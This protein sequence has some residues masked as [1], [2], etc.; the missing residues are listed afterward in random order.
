MSIESKTPKPC[1]FCR[2]SPYWTATALSV[3]N[4]PRA[5]GAKFL[6]CPRFFCIASLVEAASVE[7]WNSL[8]TQGPELDRLRE[9]LLRTKGENPWQA[10]RKAR[11]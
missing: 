6:S 8:P 1:P 7:E 5:A 10:W 11:G 3:E 2:Q 4:P 9:V